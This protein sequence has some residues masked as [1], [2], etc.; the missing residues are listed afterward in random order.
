MLQSQVKVRNLIF[1]SMYKFNLQALPLAVSAPTGTPTSASSNNAEEDEPVGAMPLAVLAPSESTLPAISNSAD[2]NESVGDAPVAEIVPSQD[3][4]TAPSNTAVEVESR[5]ALP[6]AVNVAMEVES[7]PTPPVYVTAPLQPA[8]TR[9]SSSVKAELPGALPSNSISPPVSSSSGLN[10]IGSVETGIE[11]VLGL[12]ATAN[13]PS[14]NQVEGEVPAHVV[15]SQCCQLDS[16]MADVETKMPAEEKPVSGTKPW[17]RTRRGSRKNRSKKRLSSQGSSALMTSQAIEVTSNTIPEVQSSTSDTPMVTPCDEDEAGSSGTQPLVENAPSDSI[18]PPSDTWIEQQEAGIHSEVACSKSLA[19]TPSPPDGEVDVNLAE[20]TLFSA[21]DVT[22]MEVKLVET[23]SVDV[24]S[25]ASQVPIFEPPNNVAKVESVH[26]PPEVEAESVE[27]PLVAVVSA[28]SETPIFEPPNNTIEVELVDVEPAANVETGSTCALPEV[29]SADHP[30]PQHASSEG[31]SVVIG[32]PASLYTHPQ[33]E[34]L[35]KSSVGLIVDETPSETPSENA[36]VVG[37]V[38]VE[39]GSLESLPADG[40]VSFVGWQSSCNEI[41]DFQPCDSPSSSGRKVPPTRRSRR[42]SGKRSSTKQRV[43]QDQA[44][45]GSVTSSPVVLCS[46]SGTNTGSVFRDQLEFGSSSD[47]LVAETVISY[48]PGFPPSNSGSE[49]ELLPNPP[50]EVEGVDSPQVLPEDG[51]AH[52]DLPSGSND[53]IVVESEITHPS[54]IMVSKNGLDTI[55]SIENGVASALAADLPVMPVISPSSSVTT[56]NSE[57]QT[58]VLFKEDEASPPESQPSNNEIEIESIGAFVEVATSP[59]TEPSKANSSPIFNE[60]IETESASVLPMGEKALPHTDGSLVLNQDADTESACA[61]PVGETEPP[62]TDQVLVSNQVTKTHSG[63]SVC[64]SAGENRQTKRRRRRSSRKSAARK[65]SSEKDDIQSTQL[66]GCTLPVVASPVAEN[67]PS[68]GHLSK[69]ASCATDVET[70]SNTVMEVDLVDPPSAAVGVSVSSLSSDIQPLYQANENEELACTL[71]VGE[72]AP[73]QPQKFLFSKQEAGS[74]SECALPVDESAPPHSNDNLVSIEVVQGDSPSALPASEAIPLVLA[75]PLAENGACEGALFTSTNDVADAETTLNTA[76][77]MDLTNSSTATVA[78]TSF[79]STPSNINVEADPECELQNEA[80]TPLLVNP[81]LKS[82]SDIED[83]SIIMIALPEAKTVSSGA[84]EKINSVEMGDVSFLALEKSAHELSS[85]DKDHAE[86]H[87]N[88]LM[89]SQLKMEVVVE[90]TNQLQ[91]ERTGQKRKSRRSSRRSESRNQ[92]LSQQGGKL[93]SVAAA[94]SEHLA[95]SNQA[96]ESGSLLALPV[97][98][99]A[100]NDIESDPEC[101][102]QNDAIAASLV[103]LPLTSES[104]MQDK[105][106][107]IGPL[108]PKTETIGIGPVSVFP[109]EETANELSSLDKHPGHHAEHSVDS[110]LKTDEVVENSDEKEVDRTGQKRKSRRSSRRSGSRNQRLSQK[111]GKLESVAAASS[112]HLATSNQA[113]ESGSL[114]A[115]PVGVSGQSLSNSIQLLNQGGTESACALPVGETAPAQPPKVPV[116]SQVVESEA[117]VVLPVDETANQVADAETP[118]GLPV[119][120]TAPTHSDS[121][122]V[123]NQVAGTESAMALNAGGEEKRRNRKRKDN[124]VE[125]ETVC[126]LQDEGIAPSQVNLPLMSSTSDIQVDS[127]NALPDAKTISSSA[128]DDIECVETGAVSDLAPERMINEELSMEKHP[129]DHHGEHL[130]DSQLDTEAVVEKTN[131]PPVER[132]GQKRKS[133][134]SSRRSGSRNQRLSQQGGKLESVAAASCEHLATSNQATESG[135]LLALPVGVSGQS[136]SNSI[137]LLNQGGTESAC[138]LPV[139]ETAP[140]QPPKVPVLSQVVESEAAVVLPVDETANQV[141]DAETPGD[142]RGEHLVDSQLDTEAVVE[143]T[144]QLPV[145]RTGQKRQSRRSS[146]RSGSRKQRLSQKG[147]KLESVAAASSSAEHLVTSNQATESGSL[148]ALPVGVSGQSLSNSVQLLNQEGGNESDCALPVGETAPAQPQKVLVL[149]RVVESEAAVVLPVDETSNQVADAETPCGLP[150]DETA[151][152]HSDSDLVSNQVAGTKSACVLPMDDSTPPQCNS[153]L[154]LNEVVEIDSACEFPVGEIA[155]LHSGIEVHSCGEENQQ[156]RKRKRSSRKSG[157]R[158]QSSEDHGIQSTQLSNGALSVVAPPVAENGI[159]ESFLSLNTTSV[160]DVKTSANTTMAVDV[161]D[162]LPV[163]VELNL[164]CAVPGPAESTSCQVNSDVEI[165]VLQDEGMALS[166]GVMEEIESVET[167]AIPVMAL[168]RT[169]SE[170]SSLE[171]HPRDHCTEHLVDNQL[172]TEVVVETTNQM[173]VE[174]TGQERKSR[175]SS[176]RSGTRK[177][178]L[179]NQRSKLGPVATASSSAEH[180]PTADQE[181]ESGSLHVLPVGESGQC[182]WKSVQQ[183]N[184]A[185]ETESACALPV[186]ETAPSQSNSVLVSNEDV[187]TDSACEFLV[188]K[189]ARLQSSM[190]LNAGGEEKRPNRKRKRSSCKSGASKQSLKEECVQS[191]HLPLVAS[192][193]AEN[194]AACEDVVFTITNDVTDAETP[195]LAN[196]LT[197]VAAATSCDNAPANNDI[198]SDPECELQNDTITSSLVNLP[199]T[200][201]SDMQDELIMIGPLEP[202]TEIIG[203]GPVSV[204]APE[205]TANELSSLDKHPGHHAE[206]SVD[207][208]LK[209]DEVVDKTDEKE[210]DR[211]GQKRKSR[212]SSRRSGSRKQRLSQ[213]GGKLESVAAASSLAEHLATSNQ[214]TD[215]GSLLALPVGVSGQSLSNSV[216]LLNQEGGNESACALPV[217]ETA[218][219]QPPK[220]PVLSQV[221]ESEAAFVLPV[222]ETSNQV[223]DAETPCGLPVDE[224]APPHSDSDLVSNQVAGT[225]SACVL[226]VGETAP[227]QTS[228]PLVLNDVGKTD[229]LCDFL[230]GKTFLSQSSMALNAGG[231]E[232]GPNRK[233][234]G[235]DLK[236]EAVCVLQDEGIAPSQVN[237]PL[238]SSAS[239]IQVDSMNALPDAKTV[240]SS[241]MDD[242]ECVET[243]AVS[244]LA[245]ERMINEELSMEKDP[246]DHREEHLVDSQLETEAVVEKTDQLPVERTGQ[247]RKSRRSSRRSGSRNQRLSQQGGKLESVA[248]ASSSAE[249]LATSNQATES[250][251][252][253]A[254]PVGV[255]GQSLSNSVQLLNQEGGNESDCALPVGKTAPAQPQKVLVLSQV[256]ESEA[257]VVLPVDET[258]NQVADAETPCGLPVD[259]T[260]PPHSDSDLVSNQVAGTKSACVL[261]MDDS[262]PLQCNSLLVLNEVVKID[263]ACEFPVG[264]I[265]LSRS[266]MEVHSGG[267]ENRLKRKRKR[268]SGKSGDRKPSSKEHGIQSFS[269]KS[270]L[271]VEAIIAQPGAKTVSSGL[272]EKIECVETG[273]IPV[274]ALERTTNE[275]FSFE[276]HPGDHCAG[277]LVDSPLDTEV[278]VETTNPLQVERTGQERKSRRSSR[279][280]GTRKQRLSQQR[281]K[282][283]S[284]ATASSSAECLPTSDQETKSGSLHL[285]PV[286]ESGQYLCNSVQLLNQAAETESGCMLREGETAPPFSDSIQL[287]NQEAGTESACALLVGETAPSQTNSLLVSNVVTPSAAKIF[288]A[289]NQ[290]SKPDP[291]CVL[292]V[293][294]LP[295]ISSNISTSYLETDSVCGLPV[296][297]VTPPTR[298]SSVVSLNQAVESVSGFQLPKTA[299]EPS[300]SGKWSASNQAIETASAGA[301]PMDKTVLHQQDVFLVSNQVPETE[302]ACA[303]PVCETA[304]AQSNS[305]LVSNQLPK[306]EPACAF[307]M[308]ESAP[309][310]MDS[311]VVSN[312]V[313]AT[314]PPCAFAMGETAPAQMDSAVVS[315]QVPEPEPAYAFPTGETAPAQIDSAVVSNQLPKTE[316]PSAF[317]MGETAPAQID[318]AVVSNQTPE[319]EPACAFPMGETA[320]TQMESAMVSK[321]VPETEPPCTF[322]MG[323]TAPAQIDSAVVSNQV[324][325]TEPACAFPMGETAPAQMDSAMVS[326]Q[327]PETDPACAFPMGETAPAQVDS[328]VVSNQVPETEP[329]CAFPTG[330]T[331]PAQIDSAVVSNQVPETEPACAFPTGETAPAQIDSA[332]VSNQVS[333]T[334]PA[335]AFPAVEAAPAQFDSELDFNQEPETE[336]ACAFPLGENALPQPSS[337]VLE[338]LIEAEPA[339]VLP[340]SENGGDAVPMVDMYSCEMDADDDDENR[341]LPAKKQASTDLSAW[342]KK[343]S[344]KGSRKR[345]QKQRLSQAKRKSATVAAPMSSGNMLAW[346]EEVEGVAANGSFPSG[347]AQDLA[348][349]TDGD[350]HSPKMVTELVDNLETCI[351]APEKM[352]PN[353]SRTGRKRKGGNSLQKTGKKKRLS[354]VEGDIERTEIGLPKGADMEPLD[355]AVQTDLA[356]TRSPIPVMA[357]DGIEVLSVVS[358]GEALSGP[359]PESAVTPPSVGNVGCMRQSHEGLLGGRLEA[360]VF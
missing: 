215:S 57:A 218:P 262:T 97:G 169:T 193:M 159:G 289:S 273:T 121:D 155:L 81:P 284:V 111:G 212:R 233:R 348:L 279:R 345:G 255:S 112:E 213:K 114:L 153:L 250:G 188:G 178:R 170:P 30:L 21:P 7:V 73:A 53:Q 101:E 265:A 200:S 132:T 164:V 189:T 154:V 86:N 346:N 214:A 26:V 183:L 55:D 336:P 226:P 133:R 144:D 319:T 162:A 17:R 82:E 313:P 309:T 136:L 4:V 107:M 195:D 36:I 50:M 15:N 18:S 281:G 79:H 220:V 72:T 247:K 140:A 149:S 67:G 125:G 248:A 118:Y 103:N 254:L 190:A 108:E 74:E 317:P 305:A 306:T 333:E 192:P 296:I 63:M 311:A 261:P 208:Q 263:S 75:S 185:A 34:T 168:E 98:A 113:T 274:M 65:Q 288:L 9:S 2:E 307:P 92:R 119:D 258:S 124:D 280:S 232:K 343:G 44:K 184:Q 360:P 51:M 84:I 160:T 115:L 211:T 322:P 77:E 237:L 87:V 234:K 353:I 32:V 129:G 272:M 116:L 161:V 182:L 194:G 260:A 35:G 325:E 56:N 22:K 158:K 109:L 285:L 236:D 191:S 52:R 223:A 176:R 219:A 151:P 259:E 6:V 249:H 271:Q 203:I 349:A 94:S 352:P 217:G 177:Q 166:S 301:A 38:V 308:G 269:S 291:P 196:S 209:T 327:V 351:V 357:N 150:V 167:G 66:S 46:V 59:L 256:V 287:L 120:E 323:E 244:D 338:H 282:L 141:A 62:C 91:V 41:A 71:P 199:L 355:Q 341:L 165:G 286:G 12:D 257:A 83:D 201:E 344:D 96:T 270:D 197:A 68:E 299:I 20:N 105:F 47:E 229:S 90:K 69:S 332:V 331:A 267:E 243:G 24:V 45:R 163:A 137:Q 298:S 19:L 312:Q 339:C 264:E 318:S 207:S 326:N 277:H 238:R 70:T 337:A 58:A 253:L 330:E 206:H 172:D 295:S 179:S 29:V 148:L 3:H 14:N 99:P 28:L 134:R 231:E 117:A 294:S 187:E 61:L 204:L 205:E 142:H 33:E 174:R 104:D 228:S 303:F 350:S 275:P 222:D 241:A 278:V 320:P 123:S 54:N 175:R 227:S 126:V 138:A 23:P 321:Q 16:T 302:P 147:G 292:P 95:T 173:H 335:C 354:Q 93:E 329:A 242:I 80:I 245:P 5:E 64:S 106:I 128:M 37:S 48:F 221:V 239:D 347:I 145:E 143:K 210:I 181:T 156:N 358:V 304:P 268:S 171:K 152:P 88:H 246:G 290:A 315:N 198:E 230:V 300:L 100:N 135:S 110:Q 266:G 316:P 1:V 252:L 202:K 157:D 131:Q 40:P 122:L 334:E 60:A 340:V 276:K 85:L 127:M 186:G 76:T 43:P 342:Q 224:T 225:E 42:S 297:I 283:E 13:A 146:R 356:S 314:E 39:I 216:Q 240:S 102:L 27:V 324:P 139:G 11:V 8:S 251:S 293:A 310:Q 78:E 31:E 89:D 180:L 235:N 49:V 10:L 130:V 328:A 359:V 25:A